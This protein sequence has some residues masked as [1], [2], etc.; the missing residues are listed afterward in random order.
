MSDLTN[1]QTQRLEELTVAWSSAKASE[2]AA[3]NA[4]YEIECEIY[5]LVQNQ[6]KESGVNNFPGG[7]KITTGISR[8]WD[9]EKL[10]MLAQGWPKDQRFPFA[11]QWKEDSKRVSILKEDSPDLYEQLEDA[12]TTDV[13]KPTFAVKG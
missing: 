9:Q 7:L 11:I 8:K 4:R 2:E 3:K 6:L 13:K 12:L 5:N 10:S 1:E